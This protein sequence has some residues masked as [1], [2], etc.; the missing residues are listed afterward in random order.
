MSDFLRQSCPK[1]NQFRLENQRFWRER[2]SLPKHLD[3]FLDQPFDRAKSLEVDR[4]LAY[5]AAE[6]VV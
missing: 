4:W 3:R 6:G 2:T 1:Y 5:L